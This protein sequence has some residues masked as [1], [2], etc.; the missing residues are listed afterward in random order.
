MATPPLS[1]CTNAPCPASSAPRSVVST[2]AIVTTVPSGRA[3]ASAIETVEGVGVGVAVGVGVGVG[4][5]RPSV[6][7][8]VMEWAP[9]KVARGGSRSARQSASRSA[10]PTPSPWDLAWRPAMGRAARRGSAGR[11]TRWRT[12]RSSC[13]WCPT[14]SLQSRPAAVRGSMT[15]AVQAPPSPRRRRS[16][17]HPSRP[18]R[19]PC[20]RRLAARRRRPSPRN[21]RCTRRRRCPRMSPRR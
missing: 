19:R 12:S 9:A 5:A 8:L 7:A 13:R 11:A 3:R 21:R 14:H 1:S 18:H 4:S 10:R 20:H 15:P 2:P 6:P 17:R 16:S